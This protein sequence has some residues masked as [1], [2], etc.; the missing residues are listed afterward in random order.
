MFELLITKIKNVNRIALF[1]VIIPTFSASIYYGLIASDLYVS[2]SNFIIR[3]T[4]QSTTSALGLILKGAG[5]TRSD[6]D[7]YAVQEFVLSRDALRALDKQLG[8]RAIYSRPGADILTRFPGLDPD[9]SFEELYKYYLKRVT[10]EVDSSSSISTLLV[11]SFNPDDSVKINQALLD[12]SEAL[13]NRLNKRARE[14]MVAFATTKVNEAAEKD[15]EAAVKLAKYRNT[16]NVINPELQASIPL[17]YISKLQEALLTAS[18]VLSELE[19][20]A[21]DNPQIPQLK[22][23]IQT[24]RAAIAAEN[25]KVTGSDGSLAGKA[26]DYQRLALEKEFTGKMLASAMSTLEQATADAAHQ[27]LYLEKISQPNRP[28]KAI[29][30]RRLRSLAAVFGLGLIA[31]GI[32]TMLFAAIREHQD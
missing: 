29:E 27:Q 6:D 32:F 28:D 31:W 10:V 15:R 2:E 4:D 30:P 19:A 1:T 7:S 12:E 21:K 9:D 26:A 18:T 13:V 25:A 22:V 23:R 17:Q 14:D 24:L 8:I 16:A 5:I 11:E 20:T 3:S